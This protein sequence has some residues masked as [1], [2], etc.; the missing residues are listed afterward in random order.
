MGKAT[1]L[2]YKPFEGAKPVYYRSVSNR[3]LSDRK[4]RAEAYSLMCG[5]RFQP[6]GKLF[7]MPKLK[8]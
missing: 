5:N 2:F 4:T 1:R 6:V 3:K 7:N 8:T